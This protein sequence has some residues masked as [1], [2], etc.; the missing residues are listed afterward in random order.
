MAKLH[1][2]ALGDLAVSR[3]YWIGGVGS[4]DAGA[5]AGQHFFTAFYNSIL[6]NAMTNCKV[7]CRQVQL[8]HDQFGAFIR[9]VKEA[10]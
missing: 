8:F 9:S 4:G 6:G 3:A 10:S 2:L 5:R 7:Q 1:P